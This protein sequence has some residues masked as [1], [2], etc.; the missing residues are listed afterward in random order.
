M[1]VGRIRAWLM[2]G[3]YQCGWD[4]AI[5]AIRARLRDWGKEDS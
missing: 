2:R 5:A 3:A 1:R 4:D